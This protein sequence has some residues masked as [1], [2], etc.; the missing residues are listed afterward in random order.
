MKEEMK[1]ALKVMHGGY[2]EVKE[3]SLGD[4]IGLDLIQVK[5]VKEAIKKLKK[6]I[7]EHTK[8]ELEEGVI[9][10]AMDKIFGDKLT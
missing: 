10:D 6:V 9:L 3:E 1:N 7:K 8:T 2:K 5:Y 4:K